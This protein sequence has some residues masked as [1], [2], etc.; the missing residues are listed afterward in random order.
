[1]ISGA[2]TTKSVQALEACP[3]T[4]PAAL[5]RVWNEKAPVL[6]EELQP[7]AYTSIRLQDE[8]LYRAAL[9]ALGRSG[10]TEVRL[11]AM[12]VLVGYYNPAYAAS[13]TYLT[14]GTVGD[15]IP[16]RAHALASVPEVARAT[17]LAEIQDALVN[18]VRDPDPVVRTA[19]LK[20]RQAFANEAPESVPIAGGSVVLRAGCGDRVAIES[21][22]DIMLPLRVQVLGSSYDQ[23]F[24]H[25]GMVDGRGSRTP[26]LLPKG[27]V[28]VTVGGREVARLEKRDMKCPPSTAG[29]ASTI[30]P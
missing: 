7:L 20:L 11:A 3:A 21:T 1:V 30:A 19:S 16:R 6:R 26:L 15:P 9:S 22:A 27:T 25:R 28:I 18:L 13:P 4:G 14:S 8:R 12:E 5:A 10:D 2:V 24:Y 17:R 23:A 29:P